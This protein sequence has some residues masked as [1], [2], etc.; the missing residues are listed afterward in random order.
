[1]FKLFLSAL[2]LQSLFCYSQIN[3][4]ELDKLP[5]EIREKLLEAI[6]EAEGKIKDKA[7]FTEEDFEKFE[8]ARIKEEAKKAEEAKKKKAIIGKLPN[9]VKLKPEDKEKVL[10]LVKRLGANYF[11][12]RKEAKVELIKMNYTVIPILKEQLNSSE[13]PEVTESIKEI[14]ATLSHRL[15]IGQ[16]SDAQKKIAKLP[17]NQGAAVN[18]KVTAEFYN[19]N[20]HFII[21]IGL[22]R[23]AF[24]GEVKQISSSYNRTVNISIEGRSSGGGSSSSNGFKIY[25]YSYEKEVGYW[26]I[27]GH[28]FSVSNY[29]LEIKKKKMKLKTEKPQILYFDKDNKA[30]GIL[31][32]K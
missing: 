18:P 31:D 4:K 1:M 32:L 15:H 24:E 3:Q 13:D 28:S 5:P 6:K 29:E 8:Q 21:D 9:D 16:L 10:L 7:A 2:L 17:F 25:D 11:K 20:G 27:C 22:T 23:L 26:S 12:V 14:I 30:I 19:K